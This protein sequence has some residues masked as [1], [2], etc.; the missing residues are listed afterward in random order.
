MVN[1]I[2]LSITSGLDSL[3][4]GAVLRTRGAHWLVVKIE[5]RIGLGS[6]PVSI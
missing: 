2:S 1:L 6:I 4:V 3:A 5:M